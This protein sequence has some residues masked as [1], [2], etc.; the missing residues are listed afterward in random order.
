MWGTHK[1]G[2]VRPVSPE[3]PCDA[4]IRTRRRPGQRSGESHPARAPGCPALSHDCFCLHFPQGHSSRAQAR[5]FCWKRAPGD[6]DPA[7]GM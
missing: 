4:E 5:G 1:A 3:Y 6:A 7:P 2:R